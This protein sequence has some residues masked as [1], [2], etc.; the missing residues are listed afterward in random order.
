MKY[1]LENNGFEIILDWKF[2]LD[3]YTFLSTI[4][5]KIP[6]LHQSLIIKYLLE[7]NDHFQNIIDSDGY[8]DTNYYVAKLL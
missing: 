5:L 4:I 7:K 2:G 1:F 8:S 6:Q 3:I